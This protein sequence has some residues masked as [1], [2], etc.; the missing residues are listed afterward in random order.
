MALVRLVKFGVPLSVCD[1][2]GGVV[3]GG[4][5][6]API[7]VPPYA[8]FEFEICVTIGKIASLIPKEISN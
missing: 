1:W 5:A 8:A 7:G 4:A 2:I 3:T 6:R